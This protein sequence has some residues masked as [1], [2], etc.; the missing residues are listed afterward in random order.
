MQEM[1]H[2]INLVENQDFNQTSVVTYSSIIEFL[3]LMIT[4]LERKIILLEEIGD[5]FTKEHNRLEVLFHLTTTFSANFVASMGIPANFARYLNSTL[6]QG[7]R[8]FNS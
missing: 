8:T 3:N 7:I 6:C 2:N 4:H 5:K 1:I